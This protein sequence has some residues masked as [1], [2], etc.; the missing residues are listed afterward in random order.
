M[1]SVRR[2]VSNRVYSGETE[3]LKFNQAS[4][5]DKVIPAGHHLKPIFIGLNTFTTNATAKLNVGKGITLAIFNNSAGVLSATIGDSTLVSQTVGAVQAGTDFV[6]IPLRPYTF[7]Y[8]NTFDKDYV[9]TS[10]ANALVYIVE[11]DTN[12]TQA[13]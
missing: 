10:S 11:D 5:A 3:D 2:K 8:L 7:T 1:D 12:I 6:G 13:K 4:G 9:I